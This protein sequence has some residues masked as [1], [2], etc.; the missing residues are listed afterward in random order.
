MKVFLGPL[1]MEKSCPGKEACHP[2]PVIFREH[3]YEEKLILLPKAKSIYARRDC[4]A[5]TQLTWLGEPKC[6]FG[7]KVAQL[8]Q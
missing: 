5:L 1:Y 3:F 7:E 8:G 2:S 6:L 4:F